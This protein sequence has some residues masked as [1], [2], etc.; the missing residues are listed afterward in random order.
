MGKRIGTS[1]FT[2]STIANGCN[3]WT[4]N[5]V[6]DVIDQNNIYAYCNAHGSGKVGRVEEWRTTTGGSSWAKVKDVTIFTDAYSLQLVKNRHSDAKRVFEK[7]SDNTLYLWGA[8]GFLSSD[9]QVG[10]PEAINVNGS[11]ATVSNYDLTQ[12]EGNFDVTDGGATIELTGNSWKKAGFSYNVT[13]NAVLEFDFKSTNQGEIQGI[14]FDTDN[15]LSK[16]W[17]FQVYGSQTDVGIQTYNDYSGTDYEHY[18]IN[19]GEHFTG[20][21]N[22]L[23]FV[24][25]HD[26]T[27]PTANGYFSN[28]QVYEEGSGNTDPTIQSGVFRFGKSAGGNEDKYIEWV[29]EDVNISGTTVSISIEMKDKGGMEA[30]GEWSDYL[31]AYYSVDGGAL[32]VIHEEEGDFSSDNTFYTFSV[33][34]ITG[35]TVKVVVRSK[36]TSSGYAEEYSIDNFSITSASGARKAVMTEGILKP[37]IYPNSVEGGILYIAGVEKGAVVKATSVHG[38]V[39][40]EATASS[41][42]LEIPVSKLP[43]GI[44][45]VGLRYEGKVEWLKAAIK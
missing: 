14:A 12:D 11:P 43:K 27:S 8:S 33:S 25:D 22:Y 44:V 41:D 40:Y 24:N 30:S 37:V 36:A 5:V 31:N 23:V 13:I 2:F 9:G 45:L 4:D 20:N 35:S 17:I 34:G 6:L 19:V 21:F 29:T 38:V 42:L 10:K 39:V 3:F 7:A 15:S 18:K 28:I 16:E 32:Q 1:D 26:V